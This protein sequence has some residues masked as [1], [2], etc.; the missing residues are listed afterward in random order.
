MHSGI[1]VCVD[2]QSAIKV[3]PNDI[4]NERSERIEVKYHFLKHHVKKK[5]V[6]LE[7]INTTEMVADVMKKLLLRQK[8]SF[9]K[10]QMGT[11][12]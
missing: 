5:N 6:R 12:N 1:K 10:E 9:L 4:L 8:H 2:N 7:C 11:T 3:A